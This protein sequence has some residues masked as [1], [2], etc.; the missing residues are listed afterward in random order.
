MQIVGI[1]NITP[2]SFSDG[3]EYNQLESALE[4]AFELEAN[5]ADIIDIGAESTRPGAKTINPTEEI[6]RLE[7]I[8]PAIRLSE[9]KSKISLDSYHPETIEWALE[10]NYID[11]INDISGLNNLKMIRLAS[12]C[13]LPVILMHNLGIPSNKTTI[14]ESDDVIG[15]IAIWAQ[16]KIKIAK[17]HNIS[18]DRLIIDPGIGFGKSTEQNWAIISNIKQLV[19]ALPCDIYV[20]HSNKSFLGKVTNLDARE[21]NIETLAVSAYLASQYVE[22]VRVHDVEIHKRFLSAHDSCTIN[23]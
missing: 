13:D 11:M 9:I 1:L 22:Y 23:Y 8:L 17:S 6:E 4:C 7:Q 18:S 20:G 21:R 16:E 5:G 10:H 19:D 3:G 2:D 12:K 15:D 14:M